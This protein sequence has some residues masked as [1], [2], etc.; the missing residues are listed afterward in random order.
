MEENGNESRDLGGKN[1]SEKDTTARFD[2]R[3][4]AAHSVRHTRA[5]NGGLGYLCG[6]WHEF[7]GQTLRN[8]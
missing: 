8:N 6:P 5:S 4:I 7:L 1:T 2:V 3:S